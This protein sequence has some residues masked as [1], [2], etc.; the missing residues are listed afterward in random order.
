ME[1][2]IIWTLEIDPLSGSGERNQ[3]NI[4]LV[5]WTFLSV[6]L[7]LSLCAITFD[8]M[9]WIF[10]FVYTNAKESWFDSVCLV[11]CSNFIWQITAAAAV[12]FPAEHTTINIVNSCS[13]SSRLLFGYSFCYHPPSLTYPPTHEAVS[14]CEEAANQS[15]LESSS[16]RRKPGI[17]LW[18]IQLI[19]FVGMKKFCRS[20]WFSKELPKKAANLDQQYTKKFEFLLWSELCVCMCVWGAWLD[21]NKKM[22]RAFCRRSFKVCT[23]KSEQ[24]CIHTTE[25]WTASY[26][27]FSNFSTSTG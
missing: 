19:H 8:N 3:C 6:G 7:W 24:Q 11:K 21:K 20:D 2:H 17:G 9:T 12:S 13:T 10:W 15:S 16:G 18:S 5:L 1:V 22:G 14:S 4:C 23:R 26:F 27:T 25:S